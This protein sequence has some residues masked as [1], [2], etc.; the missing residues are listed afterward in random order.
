MSDPSAQ[1]NNQPY[2]REEEEMATKRKTRDGGGDRISAA[3]ACGCN[4]DVKRQENL[5]LMPVR[6]ETN[7]MVLRGVHGGI[8]AVFLVGI[9]RACNGNIRI[10]API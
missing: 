3:P 9:F 7:V 10:N 5:S 2:K 6:R 8:G 4:G 1:H